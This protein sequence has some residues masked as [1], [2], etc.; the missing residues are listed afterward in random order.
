MELVLI[1]IVA[2]SVFHTVGH[3]FCLIIGVNIGQKI[4]QGKEVSIPNP[5]TALKEYQEEREQKEKEDKVR[6]M[7]ENIDIYDGTELGQ[8]DIGW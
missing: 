4:V 6:T 1:V 8:K 7:L 2:L 5:V 3:I